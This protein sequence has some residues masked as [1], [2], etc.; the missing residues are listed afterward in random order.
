[1]SHS[2]YNVVHIVG[3]ILFVAALGGGAVRGMA[4]GGGD[5]PSTRRL[6][7]GLHGSGLFLVLLGGFGMLARLGVMQA[8]GFPGWVWAK[9]IVWG[10]F[11]VALSLLLRMPRLA[12]P[13]LLAL[14]VLGGV[15]AY[16]A[17]YKP[18]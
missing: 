11:T 14:P 1:M 15:A 2:F 17:I 10:G 8:G 6:L 12:L 3:I 9:L 18:F 5:S 4:D 7:A 13:I 16:M